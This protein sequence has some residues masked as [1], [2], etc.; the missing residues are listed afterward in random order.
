MELLFAHAR[1][2][3]TNLCRDLNNLSK[4]FFLNVPEFWPSP[5]EVNCFGCLGDVPAFQRHNPY[6]ITGYRKF[7]TSGACVRGIFSWNN[8]TVNIWS[9]LLTLGLLTALLLE[10][11]SG[12]YQELKTPIWDRCLSSLLAVCYG[13]MLAMSTFY[14]LF[15]CTSAPVARYWYLWDIFGI[16]LSVFAYVSGFTVLQFWSHPVWM[17][18]YLVAETCIAS[19]PFYLALATKFASEKFDVLRIRSIGVLVLFSLIPML[20]SALLNQPALVAATLPGHLTVFAVLLVSFV[21]FST[22]FPEVKYPGAMD[23]LGSSHQFWH[24]GI[25]VSVLAAHEL[26][27]AYLPHR[28]ISD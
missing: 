3:K 22:R 23:I 14:H 18:V 13:V 21:V 17:A 11:H 2:L 28:D 9:N 24:L 8:E 15:S 25:S 6:I 19:A 5:S 4:R 26:Y 7:R 12:R 20:H 16:C 1:S 27:F 10:D